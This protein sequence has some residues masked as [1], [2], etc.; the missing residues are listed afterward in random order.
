MSKLSI[1]IPARQELYLQQTV[2]DILKKAA[3]EIEVIVVLDGYWPNPPLKDDKHLIIIHRERR[4]MRA[5]INAGVAVSRGEYVMKL[6]AH[7]AF[8]EGFDTILTAECDGDWVV[9]PRRYSLDYQTWKVRTNRPWVDYE[10]LGN[11][12]CKKIMKNRI[13]MHAHV[14]DARIAERC[15][16]L[17]D[18]NMTFQGSCWLTTREHFQR[19]IGFLDSTHYGTFVS[20]AQEVG[21][22]TWLG[23]GKCMVNKKAWYAHLWKGQPY[24]DKFRELYGTAYTRDSHKDTV[25]GANY[26]MDFWI[27]NRWANRIYNFEWLLE[28]FWPVPSWPEDKTQWTL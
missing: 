12:Y 1:V 19:R 16:I 2:D 17:L 18:E 6:D 21:L 5:A 10:Y 15:N 24:R 14:W 20:E 11:P 9:V 13:G 4:G 28:R 27:N 8:S 25:R 23:G 3:G 22:K 26:C 7:C